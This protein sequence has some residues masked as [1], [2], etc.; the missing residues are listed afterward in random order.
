M[1]HEF[2]HKAWQRGRQGWQQQET[3][4]QLL[5]YW[6]DFAAPADASVFVPMCGKSLDMLWLLEQGH[7]VVGV[8]LSEY[9]VQSFF[10]EN[11]LKACVTEEEAYMVYR[12]DALT[13]YAGDYF[14]LDAAKTASCPV[15]FDRAALVAMPARMRGDYVNKQAALLKPGGRVFLITLNYPQEEMQGPPF[16]VE[17]GEV[18]QLYQRYFA[19]EQVCAGPDP[20]KL[21]RPRKGHGL[22]RVGE[23]VFYL[24][25]NDTP[26]SG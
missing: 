7:G 23:S 25:R 13:I 17:D 10:R 26:F 14:A 16:S 19:V 11:G 8:E 15:V 6:D 9:G 22:S 20:A 21:D 1:D 18:R 12:C 2:W 5:R 3:N 24:T 4:P